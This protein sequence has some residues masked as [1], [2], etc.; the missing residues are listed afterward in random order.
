MLHE[1]HIQNYA[2]IEE[3]ALEFHGGLNLVSGETG[4][5]K[6]ILVDAVELALGGRAS[7][8]VIRTGAERAVV[9]AVF[10]R[11]EEPASD[12][13]SSRGGKGEPVRDP[14]SAWFEEYGLEG[15]AEPEVILRREIHSSGRTR[16]LVNDQPV[17]AGAVRA[18]ARQF[19]EVHGQGEHAALL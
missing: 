10:R 19:V 15:G 7:P 8:D 1:L 11:G 14:W 17:T 13:S 16:L 2:V 4:S 6:S 3:L 5:G 12:G 9:S 18:L